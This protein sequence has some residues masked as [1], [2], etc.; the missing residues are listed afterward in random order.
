MRLNLSR[1]PSSAS[2]W[3]K[4]HLS[5]H[6]GHQVGVS[7]EEASFVHL[8]LAPPS[9]GF[10]LAFTSSFELGMTPPQGLPSTPSTWPSA[11]FFVF[12][13]KGKRKKKIK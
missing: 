7:L 6:S 4:S 8:G 12:I 3:Q 9:L 2:W 13:I 1:E 11:A 10:G 5:S